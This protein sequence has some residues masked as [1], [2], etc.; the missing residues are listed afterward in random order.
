MIRRWSCL[1]SSNFNPDL[2]TKSFHKRF[3]ILRFFRIVNYK[4]FVYGITRFK[5]HKLS[6]FKR[7]GNWLIYSQIIQSW[8]R[9]YQ[10]N[11]FVARSQFWDGS[12]T[13]SVY[14][15]NF[16]YIKK[17]NP[18][19]FSIFNFF[20]SNSFTK[21]LYIY[22]SNKFLKFNFFKILNALTNSNTVIMYAD[23]YDEI[24]IKTNKHVI[25][26]FLKFENAAYPL[27]NYNNETTNKLF[28]LDNIDLN[29]FYWNS[30]F[31][32]NSSL[33]YKIFIFFYLK[34]IF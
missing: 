2:V 5:R 14:I 4:K 28:T 3:D 20:L 23:E 13:F 32:K 30:F 33:V 10:I 24:E 27:L 8:V 6:S 21:K 26:V 7:R 9:D 15:Y 17:K 22:F 31:F 1:N 29:I 12:K 34:K 18:L 25:P 19:S 11:K 16:F